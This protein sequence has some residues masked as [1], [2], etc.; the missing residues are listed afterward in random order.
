MKKI[1]IHVFAPR[2]IKKSKRPGF[3]FSLRLYLVFL[4]SV[5]FES[6]VAWPNGLRGAPILPTWRRQ[7]P[8]WS[9]FLALQ[10]IRGSSFRL[11]RA[12]VHNFHSIAALSFRERKQSPICLTIFQNQVG[13]IFLEL[14]TGQNNYPINKNSII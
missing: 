6:N 14:Y 12:N 8:C 9:V 13:K 4:N 1:L 5:A 7:R 11:F 2:K 3:F 10:Q